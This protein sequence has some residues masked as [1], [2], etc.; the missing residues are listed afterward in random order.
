MIANAGTPDA[1]LLAF[2]ALVPN[3]AVWALFTLV[4]AATAFQTT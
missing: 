3:I 2:L 1:K 4:H